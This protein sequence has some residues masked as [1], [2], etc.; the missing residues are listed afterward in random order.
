MRRLLG[1][2]LVC[3]LLTAAPA[4]ADDARDARV[5]LARH[6]WGAF[7]AQSG[8]ALAATASA[9]VMGEAEWD[10]GGDEPAVLLLLPGLTGA[11][12]ALGYAAETWSPELGWALAGSWPGSAVGLSLGLGAALAAG[13][14]DPDDRRLA[15]AV[16]ALA[17]ASAGA[18]TWL[19]EVLDGGRP[20]A[21]TGAFWAGG[22]TGLGAGFSA[23]LTSDAPEARAAPLLAGAVGGLVGVLFHEVLRAGME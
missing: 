12:S 7:F 10:F 19:L 14:D 18:L 6:G 11:G 20:G 16:G 9:L 21:L 15:G 23:M 4:R 2:C 8:F 13:V 17:G 1:T 5:A 22:L 3:A